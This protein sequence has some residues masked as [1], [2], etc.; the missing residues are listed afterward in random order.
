MNSSLVRPPHDQRPADSFILSYRQVP[1]G[2]LWLDDLRGKVVLVRWFM[3]SSCPE[4]S[5]TAP[6]LREFDQLYRDAG[7]AVVG[8]FHNSERSL[9]EVREIVR[10][11]DYTFPVAIDRQTATRRQWTLGGDDCGYCD[12][13]RSV[14]FLLDRR[15]VVRHVHREG[16]YVKG[17]TAYERMRAEIERL[18][19]DD[20]R[21]EELFSRPG[22]DSFTDFERIELE[23]LATA[24]EQVSLVRA[25]ALDEVIGDGPPGSRTA[26][27]QE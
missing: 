15:G 2:P 14:T 12:P 18:L 7:L 6:A 24:R 19:M 4:C 1:A 10:Q 5:A 11:F 27:N 21:F 23:S 3:D 20:P 8:M 25:A 22:A 16:R 17:D 26:K 13:Y 9:D